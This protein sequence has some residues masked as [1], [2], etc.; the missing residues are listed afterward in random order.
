MWF[1]QLKRPS[2]IKGLVQN[3]GSISMALS[4]LVSS[5]DTNVDELLAF[6]PDKRQLIIELMKPVQRAAYGENFWMDSW[7]FIIGFHTSLIMRSPTIY[8]D[9]P[10]KEFIGDICH[11]L[12]TFTCFPPP[13]RGS[14]QDEAEKISM[15]IATSVDFLMAYA[16][17]ADGYAYVTQM[18]R[19]RLIPSVLRGAAHL[20][21]SQTKN[22]G[23]LMDGIRLYTV[24]RPLLRQLHQ[25]ITLPAVVSLVLTTKPTGQF[26]KIWSDFTHA[27]YVGVQDIDEFKRSPKYKRKCY[28]PTCKVTETTK[29]F[30]EC[31]GCKGVPYCSVSC[32]KAHWKRHRE[33]CGKVEHN[34]MTSPRALSYYSYRF[35]REMRALK[36][37][38]IAYRDEALAKLPTRQ[39]L[40]LFSDYSETGQR[41][42]SVRPLS[43][44]DYEAFTPL[45]KRHPLII[46]CL[47]LPY[48]RDHRDLSLHISLSGELFGW[49]EHTE[50]DENSRLRITR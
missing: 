28:N 44:F 13:R 17:A 11:A 37:E 49:F 27:I 25:A 43:M 29:K 8:H 3:V 7:P 9:T 47:R 16:M 50:G 38:I 26:G 20:D 35:E 24:I 10:S 1:R 34:P 18:L 48:G 15:C 23:F 30:R 12:E 42:I 5:P 39:P 22:L 21:P 4:T 31:C 41:K 45:P 19:H 33:T 6:A 40:I 2:Y 32:Q 46:P 36:T 14:D